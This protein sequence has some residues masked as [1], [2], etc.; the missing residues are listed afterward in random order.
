MAQPY[1]LTLSD[2]SR[3]ELYGPWRLDAAAELIGSPRLAGR[4]LHV[5]AS[6][7]PCRDP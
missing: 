1:D 6:G 7:P 3:H 4:T 5:A 2:G